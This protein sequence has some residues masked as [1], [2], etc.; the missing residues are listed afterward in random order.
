MGGSFAIENEQ[1]RNSEMMLSNDVYQNNM[2]KQR[3]GSA[4]SSLM[5]SA[6][7]LRN[8][9]QQIVISQDTKVGDFMKNFVTINSSRIVSR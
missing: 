3:A 4:M 6:R 7:K 1:G 2:V 9:D 8:V 5:P